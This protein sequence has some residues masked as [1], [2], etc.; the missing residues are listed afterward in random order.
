MFNWIVF[1]EKSVIVIDIRKDQPNGKTSIENLPLHKRLLNII[2]YNNLTMKD[3]F[4]HPGLQ[5]KIGTI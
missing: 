3:Y 2:V 1:I 5:I 4:G